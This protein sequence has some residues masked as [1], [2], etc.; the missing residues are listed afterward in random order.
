MS[1]SKSNNKK[2]RKAY[3]KRMARAAK[4][5]EACQVVVLQDY[6]VILPE[7][8]ADVIPKPAGVCSDDT[9]TDAVIPGDSP[10]SELAFSMSADEKLPEGSR[11]IS[12]SEAESFKLAAPYLLDLFPRGAAAAVIIGSRIDWAATA[13]D[14]KPR[15]FKEGDAIASDHIAARS[16]RQKQV[17][18]ELLT[19][20]DQGMRLE[21]TSA[22]IAEEGTIMGSIIIAV[23]LVNPLEMAFDD[24]APILSELFSDGCFSYLTD[25]TDFTHHYGDQL[26][27]LPPINAVRSLDTKKPIVQV[28]D[29]SVWGEECLVGSF[30]LFDEKNP[31]MPTGTFGIAAPKRTAAKL[32]ESSDRLQE[33][34]EQIA[35]AMEGL[36][37]T[38]SRINSN[39]LLLKDNIGEIARLAQEI[40]DILGYIKQITDETR[41]LGI[42]AAIEAARAGEAGRGFGVVADEIRKLSE[43]S[44]SVVARIHGLTAEID[45]KTAGTINSSAVTLRASELQAQTSQGVAIETERLIKLAEEMQHISRRV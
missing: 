24:L 32:R 16:M 23:P 1:K 7:P 20:P 44:R 3:A 41:M 18:T 25:Q 38:A 43:Q 30:P 13:R 10:M 8:S 15:I 9:N 29:S 39:E 33:G 45:A 14:F 5:R 4:T 35:A 42:Y 6:K 27:D 36:S 31:A 19:V 34:L 22:P 21:A 28:T 2:I 17:L 12:R 40:N 26:F 11:M 37:S